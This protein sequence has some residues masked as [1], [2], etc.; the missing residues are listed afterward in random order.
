MKGGDIF[1]KKPAPN[2]FQRL[3]IQF[4]MIFSVHGSEGGLFVVIGQKE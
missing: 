4:L 3:I 2:F 1:Q